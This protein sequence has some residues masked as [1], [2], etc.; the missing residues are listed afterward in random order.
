MDHIIYS[1]LNVKKLNNNLSTEEF[2]ECLPNLVNAL[3]DYGF[4]RILCDYNN[5]SL[6]DSHDDW[7]S[8]KQKQ[9]ENDFAS[10]TSIVGMSIIKKNMSHL[11][12]V[13]S[14]KGVC[15]RDQWT[16]ENIDKVLRLNRKTHSTPY[17]SEIIRQLGFM[18]GTSKVT[19]Y[20]PLLTKRIVDT[21]EAKS[22]LD[23]CV[24]WG[25]RMLGSVCMEGIHYTGIEPCAKTY[26]GLT[27][28]VNELELN[29]QVTLYHDIA[30]NASIARNI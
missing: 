29:D 10:S 26:Q 16:H 25:G 9:I 11:Y 2:E 30:E 6:K 28:I 8:L 21:F 23:V 4:E 7:E 27:N 22:V 19:I 14:H 20:R 13:K 18:A 15:I 17:V 1:Y 3:Y 24:G 5:H 12:D